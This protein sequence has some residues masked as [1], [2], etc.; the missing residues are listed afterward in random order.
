[1][2]CWRQKSQ[3]WSTND[4]HA[5]E[6]NTWYWR[7]NHQVRAQERGSRGVNR[8]WNAPPPP[9]PTH[10]HPGTHTC[11]SAAHID[12]S[13]CTR[14]PCRGCHLAETAQW[15]WQCWYASRPVATTHITCIQRSTTTTE[16]NE[17]ARYT[18]ATVSFVMLHSPAYR[19]QH[20]DR[21]NNHIIGFRWKGYA[22]PPPPWIPLICCITL[23][24]FTDI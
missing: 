23:F 19:R 7:L 16:Y 12:Y 5:Y 17:T 9:P 22:P 6:G 15:A 20:V 11:P 13:S 4:G 3:S 21:E 14:R 1:M 18:Q 2:A 8:A 10:P 24:L